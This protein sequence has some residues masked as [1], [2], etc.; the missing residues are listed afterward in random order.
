MHKAQVFTAQIFTVLLAGAAVMV[1][2]T[3]ALGQG[4]PKPSPTKPPPPEP[5]RP[6][7]GIVINPTAEE[8]QAGWNSSLAWTKEQFESF[9][10]KLKAAK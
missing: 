6:Q 10:A 3:P 2:T 7:T 1:A 8:C 5:T 4:P 9:C